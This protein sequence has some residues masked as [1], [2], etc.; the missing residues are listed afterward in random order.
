MIYISNITYCAS[1]FTVPIGN[2]SSVNGLSLIQSYMTNIS[3]LTAHEATSLLLKTSLII[4]T[5]TI[6]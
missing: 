4:K 6:N 3:K 2:R 1:L 5:K